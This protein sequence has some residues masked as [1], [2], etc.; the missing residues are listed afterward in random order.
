MTA[1]N[2]LTSERG[3][4]HH[5]RAA[6]QSG[7]ATPGRRVPPAF[8][9]RSNR[10][11]PG[12]RKLTAGV[13]LVVAVLVA[14]GASLTAAAAP[15]PG[16]ARFVDHGGPVLHA[17]QLHLIYWGR[18]WTHT[19]PAS[20]TPDQITTALQTVLD[21][22]YLSGLAQYRGIGRGS[23]RGSTVITTSDPSP[24][25]TDDDISAFLDGQIDAGTVPGPDDGNQTLYAVIIPAGVHSGG[26]NLDGAHSYD[27]RH[28]RRIHLL[29]T[30]DSGDLARATRITS[31]ELVE[32][33]TDP[34]GSAVSGTEGTCH[35]DG[36][37]EIADVCSWAA[38][39]DGVTVL[40]Y[41]SNLAQACVV[42]GW[43]LPAAYRV[44]RQAQA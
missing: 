27:T 44:H 33:V 5:A 39:L 35:E 34:E 7:S 22:S 32:A 40:S 13:S 28:D 18:A 24:G 21:S 38:V 19:P 37:C 15:E 20:P 31:H 42:P 41:W 2:S 12:L 30:A 29:W 4:G 9:A 1:Q 23:V 10:P 43:T 6:T 8:G 36:W 11:A 17:V 3:R 25:F 26:G 16:A 14:A